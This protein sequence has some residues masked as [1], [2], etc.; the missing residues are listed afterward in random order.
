MA[1]LYAYLASDLSSDVT[2]RIFVA[3]GGFIG[4]FDRPTPRVLGYRDHHDAGPWSVEH[5]HKTIGAAA[6]TR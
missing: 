6:A 4:S 5:L 2:G 1:P 3:A